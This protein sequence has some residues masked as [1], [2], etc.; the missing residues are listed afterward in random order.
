MFCMNLQ[1]EALAAKYSNELK[2]KVSWT[3]DD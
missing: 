1:N 2:K 3:S